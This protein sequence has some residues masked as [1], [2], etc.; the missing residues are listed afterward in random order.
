MY[1][2]MKHSLGPWPSPS[3]MLLAKEVPDTLNFLCKNQ[4]FLCPNSRQC[5]FLLPVWIR[6]YVFTQVLQPYNAVCLTGTS[7]NTSIMIVSFPGS[8][9]PPS[10]PSCQFACSLCDQDAVQLNS[11]S[12]YTVQPNAGQK[13]TYDAVGEPKSVATSISQHTYTVFT[14]CQN[15]QLFLFTRVTV[16]SAHDNNLTY[17]LH[18]PQHEQSMNHIT[19]KKGLDVV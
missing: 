10:L 18:D 6:N 16:T 9:L 11:G 5:H 1:L 17:N 8:A 2:Y 3:F 7:H 15:Y 12:S 14:L 19:L 4:K 13:C